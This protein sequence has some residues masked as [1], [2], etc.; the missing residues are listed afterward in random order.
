MTN[1]IPQIQTALLSLYQATE[2]QLDGMTRSQ[3]YDLAHLADESRHNQQWTARVAA[4]IVATA[5][6]ERKTLQ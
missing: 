1:I 3:L 5:V 6:N 4:E 2:R